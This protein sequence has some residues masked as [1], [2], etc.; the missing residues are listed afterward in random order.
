MFFFGV[1]VA[2]VAAWAA[3]I[4]KLFRKGR[5]TLGFIALAGILIPILVVVGY[6][7]WFVKPVDQWEQLPPT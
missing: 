4:V 6:A 2:L 5:R 1:L 3:G 7:G